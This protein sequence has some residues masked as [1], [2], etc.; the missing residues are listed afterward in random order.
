VVRTQI[1][2]TEE[3]VARLRQ[4]ARERRASVAELIRGAVDRLLAGEGGLSPSARRRRALD[5]VGRFASGL[6]DV[7]ARHDEHLDRI[8]RGRD[9]R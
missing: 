4:M 7:S 9:V 1:Q 2:L 6:A 5:A 8:Y 3:Q